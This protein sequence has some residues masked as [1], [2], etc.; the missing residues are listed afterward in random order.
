MRRRRGS[1][2][3]IE[4]AVHF[5]AA[6]CFEYC[7]NNDIC[8]RKDVAIPEAHDSIT[9][10]AHE[11]VATSIIVLLFDVLATVQLDD[12]LGFKTSEI[13]DIGSERPLATKAKAIKLSPPQAAPEKSLGIGGVLAK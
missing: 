9:V 6:Q 4:P 5:L 3:S 13:A 8:A 1:R 11:G 7:L 2:S 12:Q 10:K